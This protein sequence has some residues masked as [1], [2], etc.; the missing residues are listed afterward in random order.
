MTEKRTPRKRET[1]PLDPLDKKT[2]VK[3]K[4]HNDG[5]TLSAN[6]RLV[7]AVDRLCGNIAEFFNLMLEA[8]N[9]RKRS[10]ME[11]EKRLIEAATDY[12]VNKIRTDPVYAERALQ[13][14]VGKAVNAQ[15][16]KDNVAIEAY[17]D[18][19]RQ[20]P[21]ADV[22]GPEAINVEIM[23]RIEFYASDASTQE[24]RE[25][26]GRVLAGEIR[27]PGTFSLK[28]L[29]VIDEMGADTALLFERICKDRLAD[30]VPQCLTSI[31]FGEAM[32][33][34]EADLFQQPQTLSRSLNWL[35]DADDAARWLIF[36][37]Y[38]ISFEYNGPLPEG[39]KRG[40][41]LGGGPGLSSYALTQSALA[42]ASL[43]D[44]T[45]EENIKRLAKV[46]REWMPTAEI[47]LLKKGVDGSH[48]AYLKYP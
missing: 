23:D 11:G 47:W 13:S 31:H 46:F 20:P 8:P 1:P 41:H 12:A 26:W 28:V 15:L 37:E 29:R 10:I 5:I 18:L 21:P 44:Y 40:L 30:T 48:E 45:E 27:K 2:E 34:S 22:S 9:A 33:L 4:L 36:D 35:P 43:L 6:S 42:I 25:R 32:R 16:N 3:A 24:L 38:G 39:L 17:Q 19:K 14:I 7:N